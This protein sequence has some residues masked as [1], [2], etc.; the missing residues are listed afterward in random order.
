MRETMLILHLIGLAMGLGT[1]FAHV[2]LGNTLSKLDPTEAGKFRNQSKGLSLMGTVGTVMLFVSGVYLIIPFW[3]IIT[4]LPLLILKLILFVI[5]VILIV[6]INYGA[7]NNYQN[8]DVNNLKRI[9]LMG[10]FAMVIGVTIV[11]LAVNVFN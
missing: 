1:S 11:I 3:P 4:T 10:K 9:E 5:L 8:N 6:L 2:F 7:R